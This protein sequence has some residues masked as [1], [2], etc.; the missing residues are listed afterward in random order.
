MPRPR[1][2]ATKKPPIK[3]FAGQWIRR[4]G[5]TQ[6]D[7]ALET[8]ITEQY[9]S[10]IVNNKKAPSL[11]VAIDLATA[12]GVTVDALRRPPPP[13]D[14]AQSVVGLSAAVIEKLSRRQAD[15]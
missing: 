10:E 8:D 11:E 15:N 2:S 12:L 13:Q 4:L 5:R 14:S 3:L 1:Q 7:V 6:A 9:L